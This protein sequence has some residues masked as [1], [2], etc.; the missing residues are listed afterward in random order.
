VENEQIE[1]LWQEWPAG[2]TA[3]TLLARAEPRPTHLLQRGDWLKPARPVTPGVPAFLHPLPEPAAPNRLTLARWLVDRRSPTT[4]RVF[5]NRIWQAYFGSGIVGTPEDFGVQSEAP[6]HPELL[7]WLACEFMER[8][9]GMK[10]MHRLIVTSAAYRQSSRLTPVL[11]QRDPFNRLLARGPRFR[12]EGEIVRDLSLAVSG[13]L[14]SH[15]GGRSVMPP[16]PP[17]LFQPPASYAP[18]PWVDEA[19]SERYR[20][21]LYTFRRRS[22]PYPVLQTFD[23]PNADFSCVRR[24]RSN[25]PLQALVSLNEPLFVDCARALARKTIEEG[26]PTDADRLTYAFR[27]TLARRPTAE[28]SQEL[29]AL[30]QKQQRRLAE[31]ALNAQEIAT[32]KKE[33]AAGA[34]A[35][36]L[37]AYTV[38]CRVLLN[39]DE[40][41]TKE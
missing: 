25:S 29:L 11:A 27:R 10:E 4:A 38:V 19:G 36:Q 33:P 39:L 8:G 26:G 13:L 20:R 12:V 41:I 23:V 6:N 21:A 18:F 3:L 32:G 37:A 24:Q 31:G 7:D 16:A 5:V 35:N 22:T 14:N 30:L 17:F 15:I 2:S 9:W 40:T 34:N 28:E 1:A